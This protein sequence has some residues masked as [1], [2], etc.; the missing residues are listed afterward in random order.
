QFKGK[1]V[2]LQTNFEKGKHWAKGE[3]RYVP[4]KDRFQLNLVTAANEAVLFEGG[5][6][7][8]VLTLEREDAKKN[9]SQ[10][11]VI[12]MLHSNRYLYRYEVKAKD[13]PQFARL[14]QVGATKEG[15]PFAGGD[16]A[17]ECVVSGGKG[18]IAVSY[19]G[20]TYYVCCGGCRDAFK[21][22]PE[23]YIKEY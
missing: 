3:L 23:K 17:P 6:K 22:E 19:M 1:D 16:G 7:D 5:L 12:T 13:R 20:K 14:Y 21:D 11:F 18:T 10:R 2:W 8:D 4:D 9:E 15:E